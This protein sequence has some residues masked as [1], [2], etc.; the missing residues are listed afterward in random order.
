MESNR[1]QKLKKAQKLREE[2]IKN[3][4]DGKNT[5]LNFL[6]NNVFQYNSNKISPNTTLSKMFNLTKSLNLKEKNSQNENE[7]LLLKKQNLSE[8]KNLI[9]FTVKKNNE[10]KL[11][12]I[13]QNLIKQKE[14]KLQK[15]KQSQKEKKE[16]EERQKEFENEEKKKI[17]NKKAAKEYRELIQKNMEDVNKMNE[18]NKK[19][20]KEKFLKQI[21]YEK[22]EIEFRNKIDDFYKKQ[23]SLR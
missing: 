16:K 1:K 10:I 5:K 21:E 6:T 19:K 9:D 2:I 7:L 13:K 22:Q 12:E 17:E 15:M 20:E 18:L 8:I 14:E 4:I 3:E 11:N 23:H